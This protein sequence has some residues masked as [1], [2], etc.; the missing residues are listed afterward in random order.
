MNFL[1][2]LKDKYNV[3]PVQVRASGWFLICIIIQKS[4]SIISTPIFTRLMDAASY[5]QYSVFCSWMSIF[6]VV[7]SLNLYAGVYT[8]GLIKF[9]QDRSIFSS[10]L[11]FLS[12]ILSLLWCLVYLV[13][14]ERINGLLGFTTIQMIAMFILIW[15]SSAYNFW[16]TEERVCSRYRNLVRLTI[17]TSTAKLVLGVVFVIG[18]DDKVSARI[19]SI[20]VVEVICFTP[21]FFKQVLKG[22]ILFSRE[23]W[24]Y[25]I[26]YSLVLI[27]HYLS[28]TVLNSADSIMIGRMIGEKEAGIY[29]LAYSLGML[30]MII[31]TALMQSISPWLYSKIKEKKYTAIPPI[32]YSSIIFVAVLNVLLILIAPELVHLF[33]PSEYY[34]AIWIIP[35]VAMS[36]FFIYCYDLFAKF[37]FYYEKTLLIMIPSCIVAILNIILNF[38]FIRLFGYMAAGFTT[39]FCY[40]FYAIFHYLLMRI[41]CN[42]Y[43]GGVR[44]YNVTRIIQVASFFMAVSFIIMFTYKYVVIR[45][46]ALLFS[47]LLVILKRKTLVEKISKILRITKEDR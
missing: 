23:Y 32:A 24:S 16:A 17:V 8:Q 43:C 30:M 10:S 36:A 22:R 7:V 44:V 42:R 37:A 25:S 20:L 38:F 15:T 31:N 29:G 21:L 45:Y 11:Q 27:P 40:I 34:D 5:G 4:V 13:L 9:D 47:L 3:I 2:D 14:K 39:L 1:R 18:I 35:P 12:L 6:T 41:I 33:A 19:L 26:R 28:Q 46:S